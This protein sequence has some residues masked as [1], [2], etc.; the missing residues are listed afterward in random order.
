MHRLPSVQNHRFPT[1]S[2]ATHIR[3]IKDDPR[4]P[5]SCREQHWSTRSP[6]EEPVY[7]AGSSLAGLPHLYDSVYSLVL[8]LAEWSVGKM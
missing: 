2:I 1:N 3:A 4:F 7:F 8:T 5:T 6:D